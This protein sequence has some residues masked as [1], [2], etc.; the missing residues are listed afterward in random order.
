MTQSDN[1]SHLQQKI[2]DYSTPND[3]IFI[4]MDKHNNNSFVIILTITFSL[5]LLANQKRG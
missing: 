2:N 3:Y 5:C 1:H 4:K